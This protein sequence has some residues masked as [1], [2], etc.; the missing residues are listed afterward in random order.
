MGE[1]DIKG[2]LGVGGMAIVYKAYEIMLDREVA[3]K[4]LPPQM[5]FGGGMIER[6]VREAKTAAKLNHPNIIPIYR[7]GELGRTVYFVMKYVVGRGLDEILED[8]GRLSMQVVSSILQQIGGGGGGGGG[9]GGVG[10][11]GDPNSG[12]IEI[13][14]PFP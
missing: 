8:Q 13:F 5:A 9:D 10:G 3:I 4:V 1:Y 12:T 11:G 2:L 6:F 7:I 14:V